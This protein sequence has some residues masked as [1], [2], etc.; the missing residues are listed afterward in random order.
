[1]ASRV[2]GGPSAVLVSFGVWL[3]M[4]AGYLIDPQSLAY[5]LSDAMPASIRS[6]AIRLWPLADGWR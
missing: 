5:G 3:L 1:M 2:M 4:G 6:S